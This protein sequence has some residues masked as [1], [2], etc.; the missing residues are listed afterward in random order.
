MRY[1]ILEK[2]HIGGVWIIIE[3]V[4]DIMTWSKKNC[5]HYFSKIYD[6]QTEKWVK[7]GKRGTIKDKNNRPAFKEVPTSL[8]NLCD[9]FVYEKTLEEYKAEVTKNGNDDWDE[10]F[11]E[12]HKR[13]VKHAY[14]I[15]KNI[16][17]EVLKDYPEL[18]KK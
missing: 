13:H 14:L 12:E 8:E 5:Y 7:I 3:S 11:V 17:K 10:Y 6:M 4:D 16:R 18:I 1:L 9:E 15:G 2:S